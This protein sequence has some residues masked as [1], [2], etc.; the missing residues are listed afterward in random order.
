MKLFLSVIGLALATLRENKVRSL[1]TVLV[2]VIGTGT[3]IGVGSILTGFDGA[4]TGA[5]RSLGT[6]GIMVYRFSPFSGNLTPEERQRKPLTYDNAKAIG[7]R[8]PSVERVSPYLVPN[9][10]GGGIGILKARYKGNEQYQLNMA[11]TVAD[12]VNSGQVDMRTGRFFTD[13]DDQHHLP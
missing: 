5:I 6:N 9:G 13:T 2:V 1:L 10:P 12:Y 7:E 4:V 3:I 11:G 8:C